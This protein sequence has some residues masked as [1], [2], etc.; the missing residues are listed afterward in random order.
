MR[1]TSRDFFIDYG[2]AIIA[3]HTTALA[4]IILKRLFKND[5]VDIF[6]D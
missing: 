4:S 1:D 2:A 3:E 6:L 5:Y